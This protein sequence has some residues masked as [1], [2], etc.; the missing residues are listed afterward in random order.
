MPEPIHIPYLYININQD[1]G[2]LQAVGLQ[3]QVYIF[4]TSLN[5]FI[6]F[7]KGQ[8]KNSALM[9][10]WVSSEGFVRAVGGA[11]QEEV[12]LRLGEELEGAG[13][14]PTCRS[15]AEV[16]S[17]PTPP[18]PAPLKPAA[19]WERWERLGGDPEARLS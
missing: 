11:P 18:T 19:G 15:E 3:W 14:H 17:P 2:D 6:S 16:G 4:P 10:L 13:G 8:K 9:G 12:R 5:F 7:A 1:S